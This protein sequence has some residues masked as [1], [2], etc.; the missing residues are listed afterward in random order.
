MA[1]KD[2][3]EVARLLIDAD[4]R[5]EATALADGTG[6]VR[7]QLH[8]PVLRELGMQRKIAFGNWAVPGFR[9]LA[10]GKRLRGTPLDP[11]GRTKVRRAERALTSEYL[12]ALADVLADLTADNLGEAVRI[13][14]LPDLVRGYE[15]LKLARI[16]EFRAQLAAVV[17]K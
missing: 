4:A 12:D 5:A 6:R 2:E 17:R 7:F 13:A 9:V 3:Y 8:P 16:A 11:F 14:E 15:D 1:Y 10:R